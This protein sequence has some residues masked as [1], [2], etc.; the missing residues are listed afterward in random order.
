M[1]AEELQG[2]NGVLAIEAPHTVPLLVH[3]LL[4][5]M[6]DRSPLH[7]ALYDF[8]QVLEHIVGVYLHA[9]GAFLHGSG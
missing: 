1:L 4:A 8:K 5:L 3:H 7:T 9:L 6:K 2:A